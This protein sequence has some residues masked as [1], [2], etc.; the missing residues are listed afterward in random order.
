MGGNWSRI[1]D[2]SNTSKDFIANQSRKI[3]TVAGQSFKKRNSV[4]STDVQQSSNNF[5]TLPNPNECHPPKHHHHHRRNNSNASIVS[6]NTVKGI[7]LYGNIK[8]PPTLTVKLTLKY[9]GI[10]YEFI[11]IDINNG[12]QIKE[13]FRQVTL[14]YYY[15]YLCQ[16]FIRKYL[17]MAFVLKFSK[18]DI[19][20]VYICILY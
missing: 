18:L 8:S 12:E 10:D 17:Y 2:C 7:K 1:T 13:E 16:G 19:I 5:L 15:Y 14:L 6:N 11:S 3:S 4:A 9:L 20:V